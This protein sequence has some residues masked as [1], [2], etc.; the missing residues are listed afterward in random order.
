[1]SPC[2]SQEYSDLA[3]TGWSSTMPPRP[4]LASTSAR[5]Q[6]AGHLS[7]LNK[8]QLYLKYWVRSL[9]KVKIV[10]FSVIV[11]YKRSGKFS[12]QFHL[13]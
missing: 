12:I 13:T 7:K 10:V 6:R 11:E 9:L 3:P 4:A 1:M 8:Q 5:S 2:L